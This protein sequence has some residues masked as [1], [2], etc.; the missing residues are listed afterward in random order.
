MRK[1]VRAE[2]MQDIQD[3]L[4][5]S[6]F[7][8]KDDLVENPTEETTKSIYEANTSLQEL[9][10]SSIRKRTQRA[11]AQFE[12]IERAD[13]QLQAEKYDKQLC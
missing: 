6:Y 7:D 9:E 13:Q 10:T 8:R 12:D 5:A 3:S 1:F 4:E 11:I 2:I